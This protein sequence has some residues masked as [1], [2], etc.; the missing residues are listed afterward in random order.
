MCTFLNKSQTPLILTD[1]A[2]PD[3]L[4]FSNASHKK[5]YQRTIHLRIHYHVKQDRNKAHISFEN[6]LLYFIQLINLISES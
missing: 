2:I 6:M 3:K 1:M 4:C 5:N